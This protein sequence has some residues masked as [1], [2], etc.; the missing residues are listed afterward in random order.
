[1][2]GLSFVTHAVTLCNLYILATTDFE[3]SNCKGEIMKFIR[4]KET[5]GNDIVDEIR[6]IEKAGYCEIV[7]DDTVSIKAKAGRRI[8]FSVQLDGII[9]QAKEICLVTKDFGTNDE[10]DKVYDYMFLDNNSI[11][12]NRID[13]SNNKHMSIEMMSI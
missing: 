5:A 2:V 1:M 9:F 12:L 4:V 10:E 13:F 6:E 8:A 3:T 7:K 11:D